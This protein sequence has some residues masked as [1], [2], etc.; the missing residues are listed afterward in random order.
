MTVGVNTAWKAKTTQPKATPWEQFATNIRPERA[1][2]LLFPDTWL[3]LF[4]RITYPPERVGASP[5]PPSLGE[6]KGVGVRLPPFGKGY[7]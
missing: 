7:G 5:L 3:L 6:G 1:K 4:R 2:E